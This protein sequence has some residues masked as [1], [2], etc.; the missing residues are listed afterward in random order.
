MAFVYADRVK[1]QSTTVGLG[2]MTLTGPATG[3]Q[4]FN[5]G[6]GVGNQA[7]YTIFN[8][9]DST[10]EVGSGTL[11]AATT[12][13]RDTVLD[14]SSGGAQVNF[15]AGTKTIFAGVA[16]QFFSGAIDTAAHG[17]INHSGL[18]GVPAAET[19]DSTAH[20]AT[21]H[22]AAP[23]NLFD[24]AA[25]EATDHKAAPFNLLDEPAHD[26]LSHVGLPGVNSFDST[27]HD[28]ITH[29]AAPFNL[30]DTPTHTALDHTRVT[31]VATSRIHQSN[32]D[33]ALGTSED[34]TL[35][36]TI[37]ANTLTTDGDALKIT[38][39]LQEGNGGTLW[40]FSVAGSSGHFNPSIVGTIHILEIWVQR[41]AVNAARV[42]FSITKCQP[43]T[44]MA[45][46]APATA[47]LTTTTATDWSIAQS[48]T[49]SATGSLTRG[50][51]RH[52]QILLQPA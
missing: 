26:A 14:S 4:S 24:V 46:N 6:V 30:L 20:D 15:I 5:I 44:G 50:T 16:A 38:E 17:A 8:D 35:S 48:F 40:T 3:F 39:I 52:A 29:L 7:F 45:A 2:A 41:T 51:V 13:A 36:I 34:G 10:W 32:P 47:G 21:D 42:Q 12:L 25:H 23:F 43:G 19:F 1:E 27:A 18:P 37:P 31:G 33:H 49:T 22:S 9:A 28:A 11:T